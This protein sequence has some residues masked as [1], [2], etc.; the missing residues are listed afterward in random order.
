MYCS[1]CGVKGTGKFCTACGNRLAISG[2]VAGALCGRDI[3]RADVDFDPTVILSIDWSDLIDYEQLIS[4]PAVR[5]RIARAAAQSKKRMSGEEILDLYGKAMGKLTGVSL[6]MS[7]IAGFAQSAYAKMGVKTGKSLAA[8]FAMPTGEM[9]VRVLCHH[10]K[11]GR[12]LRDV[13]QLSDGC[14]LRASLPSD[15]LA[16]EGDLIVAVTRQQRATRI[17]AQTDIPG[18]MFDW[19]KSVR[20]LET[21][22]GDLGSAAA[23]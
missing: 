12:M 19:G 21:L 3:G 8:I 4:I 10:A 13:Q 23:A 5:D 14:I 11:N 17:E 22:L 20:C 6:P 15:L 7:T 1:E 18:Q 16:L 2:G 9:I